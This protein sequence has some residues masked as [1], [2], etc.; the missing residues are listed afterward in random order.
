MACALLNVFDAPV[1]QN[2]MSFV[3]P[4]PE[5]DTLYGTVEI[6]DVRHYITYGGVPQ[7]GFV[8]FADQEKQG[9]YRWDRDYFQEASYTKIET[10]QV[11]F[12]VHED[13]SEEIGVLPDN[14]ED[15]VN[16]D[17]LAETVM[18]AD[19]YFMLAREREIADDYY[20]RDHADN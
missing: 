8:Y 11:V 16:K 3:P 19:A 7:G 18:I 9:W 6:K 20:V 10:G 15:T 14:W 4:D 5:F 17:R 1:V 2:I 13:G 12:L